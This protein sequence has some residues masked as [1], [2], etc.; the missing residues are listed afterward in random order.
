[1]VRKIIRGKRTVIAHSE[2]GNQTYTKG[3]NEQ[4]AGWKVNRGNWKMKRIL[5]WE[6]QPGFGEPDFRFSTK[7]MSECMYVRV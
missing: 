1:M 4:D 5:I 6:N 3:G 2:R 7:G